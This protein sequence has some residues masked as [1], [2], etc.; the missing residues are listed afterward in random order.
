MPTSHTL[1]T[2]YN[3]ALD[4][5]SEFP[6]NTPQDSTAYA[7]WLNRNYAPTVETALRLDA[8]NF[9]TRF[10][11]V[12]EEAEPPVMRWKKQFRLPPG[13]LRVLQPTQDGYRNGYPL[14]WAVQGAY[15]LMNTTPRNG[16]EFIANIQNPGE[17]EPLFADMV[18]AQLAAGMAQRFT[19]KNS[20]LDRCVQLAREAKDQASEIN[21]FEGTAQTPD[22]DDIIRLRGSDDGYDPRRW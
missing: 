19:G 3:R 8:W 22:Q 10:A 1:T 4:H 9:A 5:I 15:L 21:A 13:C 11:I 16:I 2:I 17:W 14:P 20:Y 7:R 12:Q 18:A 6:V